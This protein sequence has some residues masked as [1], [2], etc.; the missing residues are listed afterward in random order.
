MQGSVNAVLVVRLGRATAFGD[1]AHMHLDACV[2]AAWVGTAES[3][4][5]LVGVGPARPD[6]F[7]R[8]AVNPEMVG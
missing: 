8:H 2:A 1:T 7:G 4:Y 6:L 5:K 3:A